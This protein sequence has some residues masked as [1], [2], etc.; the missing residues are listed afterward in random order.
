MEDVPYKDWGLTLEK[1]CIFLKAVDSANVFSPTFEKSSKFTLELLDD[2]D[3]SM[4]LG[5]E[6]S[7]C[8][9]FDW[10]DLHREFASRFLEEELSYFIELPT[11]VE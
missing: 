7:A 8:V 4:W 10:Y 3:N 9:D 6:E 5:V 11:N 2:G 1:Y